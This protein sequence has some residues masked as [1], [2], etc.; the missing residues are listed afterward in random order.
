MKK[1]FAL[2]CTMLLVAGAYAFVVNEKVLRTFNQ[3]FASAEDVKWEEYKTFY[4]VSFVHAGIRSKVTYDKDGTMMNSLRYYKPNMLPLNVL[5]VL[6]NSYPKKNLFGV[7]EVSTGAQVF[8][9]VKM[10]DDK[11]WIT[12][13]VDGVG[14]TEVYE[15]YKKA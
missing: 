6:K 4:T 14:N 12:V 3:T 10:Y 13:K 15:K 9:Y 1:T 2:F 8:Y 5:S 7:T 11:N